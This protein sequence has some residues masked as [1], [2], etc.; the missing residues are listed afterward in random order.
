MAFT[1]ITVGALS[2]AIDLGDPIGEADGL[3][4]TTTLRL[5]TSTTYNE[6]IYIN[7]GGHL[8]IDPGVVVRMGSGYKIYVQDGKLSILGG[9]NNMARIWGNGV[10]WGGIEAD[11]DATVIM[12]NCEI[13]W[14]DVGLNVIGSG[15]SGSS[16]SIQVN[17]TSFL[18][19]ETGITLNGGGR[20]GP[21][22]CRIWDTYI[23][24]VNR[25]I[26]VVNGYDNF[27]V[28]D[29][30]IFDADEMG[31]FVSGVQGNIVRN[32]TV[33]DSTFGITFGMLNGPITIDNNTI[34]DCKIGLNGGF[35]SKV[36]ISNNSVFAT[37]K[38]IWIGL[39]DGN[40][41]E[42]NIISVITGTTRAPIELES[43]TP[44]TTIRKNILS[45]C[46]PMMIINGSAAGHIITDNLLTNLT[47]RMYIDS[48]GDGYC[49]ND[50]RAD[51][52]AS[53]WVKN[54]RTSVVPK[55]ASPVSPTY[56]N[57]AQTVSNA[58]QGSRWVMLS[59]IKGLGPKSL[60][61]RE[62]YHTKLPYFDRSVYL[63]GQEKEFL[64]FYP[65]A[66]TQDTE[67]NTVSNAGISNLTIKEGATTVMISDSDNITISDIDAFGYNTF[68]MGMDIDSSQDVTISGVYLSSTQYYGL[69]ISDSDRISIEN[70]RITHPTGKG[71]FMETSFDVEA[72]NVT[73]SLA[74]EPALY[75]VKSGFSWNGSELGSKQESIVMYNSDDCVLSYIEP[76]T[77]NPQDR[78]MVV[79]DCQGTQIIDCEFQM[80]FRTYDFYGIDLY[81]DIQDTIIEGT[82]FIANAGH[83]FETF[84]VTVRGNF[85]GRCR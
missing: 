25:G 76:R 46:G 48:N 85:H 28:E 82:L 42:N 73:V 55:R 8:I 3:I 74:D 5:T 56:V 24:N 21:F 27:I 38:G 13:K 15:H 69:N 54:C 59:D 20:T 30:D 22:K 19:C 34:R 81:G 67:F 70:S 62:I 36:T 75:S 33:G 58:A 6:D 29:L 1:L 77:Y 7:T 50:V 9:V 43:G 37:E 12:Y 61:S 23:T 63:E 47:D 71:I 4:V 79:T 52:S 84:A 18:V 39:T 66:C 60:E 64:I 65:A 26:E 32:V 2:V 31:V 11:E 57:P 41:I 17:R 53:A 44:A 10:T 51:G 68:L 14:A 83:A 78:L 45:G 35:F 72:D 80:G 40:M 49:D 16:G